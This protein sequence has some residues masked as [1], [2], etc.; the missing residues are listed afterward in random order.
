MSRAV[1][2]HL[3]LCT[4]RGPEQH[5]PHL[6]G[7][8]QGRRE[9]WFKALCGVWDL[10]KVPGT[11]IPNKQGRLCVNVCGP[12]QVQRTGMWKEEV[13]G[14]GGEGKGRDRKREEERGKEEERQES[15]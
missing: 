4:L 7:R 13:G 15:N 3:P 8:A 14:N 9:A 6:S 11:E 1:C 10:F 12:L 2:T 5:L